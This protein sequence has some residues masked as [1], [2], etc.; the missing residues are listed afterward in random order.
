MLD[1]RYSKDT[2]ARTLGVHRSTIYREIKRNSFKH[3]RSGRL[4]YSCSVAQNRYLKRRKRA[5]MLEENH[6]LRTYVY[7]RLN[8]GWSPWQIEGRLKFENE[9]KCIISHESIYRHIYSDYGIRNRFYNKLR[10]KH[11]WRV[12]QRSRKA[13]IPK[14]IL[15]HERPAIINR[16]EEFGHWECDLMMFKIGFKSNLITLRERKTRFLIAIKNKNKTAIGTAT[17]LISSLKKIKTYLKSI[18][19]DQGGEFLKYEWIKDCFGTDIYFCDPASPEQKG[20]IENG[21]G[22]I[23][24]ELPRSHNIDDMRQKEVAHLINQ[25]NERPLRCL[26]F[27]TPKEAFSEF[28]GVL[29]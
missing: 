27:K 29:I 6:D 5:S 4:V 3:W 18:T 12:K 9:G 26:G 8:K 11:F 25:I 10:R 20:G 13:R 15:I 21:N 19:F 7:G 28:T 24:V 2:I 17:T 22:V 1:K 23:R 14:E 16:R